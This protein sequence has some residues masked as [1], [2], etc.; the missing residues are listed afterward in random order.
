MTPYVINEQHSV[1]AYDLIAVPNHY[2]GMGCGHYTAY[3]KN[4]DGAWYYFDDSITPTNEE[5]VVT[6]AVYVLFCQR[7]VSLQ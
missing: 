3:S 7:S 2:A 5:A 1:A 6:K 4:E